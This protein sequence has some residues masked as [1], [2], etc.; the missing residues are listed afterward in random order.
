MA[1]WGNTPRSDTPLWESNLFGLA[2][3]SETFVLHPRIAR[4]I[5]EEIQGFLPSNLTVNHFWDIMKKKMGMS[6][7]VE[8]VMV[9]VHVC[10]RVSGSV[11]R[12]HP[13]PLRPRRLKIANTFGQVFTLASLCKCLHRSPATTYESSTSRNTYI[14]IQVYTYSMYCFRWQ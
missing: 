3:F 5:V 10:C 7:L 2:E 4:V 9:N 11:F 6:W 14:Y 12:I 13:N 1:I 8:L